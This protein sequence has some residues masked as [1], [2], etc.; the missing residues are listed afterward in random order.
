MKVF[1]TGGAGYIGQICVKLLRQ[2][3]VGV[4]VYDNLST[5]HKQMLPGG[6]ELIEGDLRDYPRLAQSL[7]DYQ[8]DVV[9]HFA[10]VALV[11]ESMRAPELYFDV[12]T[13][14]GSNLLRAMLACNVKRIVVS[15]TCAVYGSSAQLPIPESLA[16]A[17]INPYGASK[18]MF[19]QMLEWYGSVHQFRATV[20]RYFNA[21]GAWDELGEDHEPETH[22]IPNVLRVAL[23]KKSH[24]EV[25]GTDYETPDGSCLRDFIHVR[26]VASAHWLAAK[27][28]VLGTFNLGTGVP[29]S[30]LQIIEQCERISGVT[31]PV[32][33]Q[34]RRPGDPAALYADPARAKAMLGWQ[35]QHS[36]IEQIIA[37]AWRWH[38]QHPNGFQHA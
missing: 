8:A 20:F 11:P 37:D 17:P 22:L 21:C 13:H 23:G 15:S 7:G 30:V 3:G 5:G 35:A 25:F 1:V 16:G 2:H 14:G 19:E 24:V 29:V 31:I 27:N 34:T 6:V 28:N 26:D 18:R 10:G 36:S 4:C 9:M 32:V 33:R 12:N 38:C